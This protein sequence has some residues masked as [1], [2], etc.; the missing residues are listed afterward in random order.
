MRSSTREMINNPLMFGADGAVLGPFSDWG[1]DQLIALPLPL[2]PKMIFFFLAKSLNTLIVT[3]SSFFM[4]IV[5]QWA[6]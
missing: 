6:R 4:L 5:E 1:T 3:G 2:P